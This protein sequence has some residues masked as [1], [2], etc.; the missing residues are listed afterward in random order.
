M[1]VVTSSLHHLLQDAFS[2][3]QVMVTVTPS[4]SVAFAPICGWRTSYSGTCGMA[5]ATVVSGVVCVVVASG[6]LLEDSHFFLTQY[7]EPS[8]SI[9]S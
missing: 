6:M 3:V 1:A 9:L 8:N 7:P 5:R 2:S 4:Q